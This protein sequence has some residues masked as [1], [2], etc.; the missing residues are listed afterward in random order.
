MKFRV[1]ETRQKV[2][3][4]TLQSV[5][6]VISRGTA[7]VE[8]AITTTLNNI[9]A[10]GSAFGMRMGA[11]NTITSMSQNLKNIYDSWKNIKEKLQ[12]TP[13]EK[14]K[15]YLAETQ[16]GQN[17]I[18]QYIF[19]KGNKPFLGLTQQCTLGGSVKHPKIVLLSNT[20]N[21]TNA[22]TFLQQIDSLAV[23]SGSRIFNR[24]AQQTG[25]NKDEISKIVIEFL[26]TNL[27][28]TGQKKLLSYIDA[29]AVSTAA[30]AGDWVTYEKLLNSFTKKVLGG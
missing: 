22:N 12:K 14:V 30:S 17:A 27:K 11:I 3:E 4:V 6:G 15:I 13:E 10:I 9:A 26:K 5:K 24:A 21:P 18:R 20:G 2:R 25:V 19:F 23:S 16:D 1:I 29:N 28:N 7:A 8:P